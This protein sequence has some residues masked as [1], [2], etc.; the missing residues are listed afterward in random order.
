MG[1]FFIELY[2][3]KNKL[4]NKKIIDLESTYK[5]EYNIN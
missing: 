5:I 3:I 4:N 1:L 2:L